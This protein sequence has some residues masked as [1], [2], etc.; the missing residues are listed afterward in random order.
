[1]TYTPCEIYTTTLDNGMQVTLGVNDVDPSVAIHLIYRVGSRNEERGRTG[2]AHLFEHLMFQGSVHLPKGEYFKLIHINGGRTNGFTSEELTVYYQTLPPHRVEMGLWLEA[3]R[4]GG[5]LLTESNIKNQKSVVIEEKLQ[6]ENQPYGKMWDHLYESFYTDFAYQHPIIGYTEDIQ[7]ASMEDIRAFY[8]TYYSPGNANLAVVGAIDPDNVMDSIA[9]LFGQ[10]GSVMV[11]PPSIE[12]A[13]PQKP[14]VYNYYD[15]KIQLPA[16]ILAYPAPSFNDSDQE[17]FLILDSLLA[18]GA[19]SRL[20]QR[21]LKQ[22]E[23]VLQID[24][25]PSIKLG[26]SMFVIFAVNNGNH[27]NDDIREQVMDVLNQLTQG[28]IS[29]EELEKSKTQL[30]AQTIYSLRQ[31]QNVAARINLN[32]MY[33]NDPLYTERMLHRLEKITLKDVQ[34]AA[35]QWLDPSKQTCVHILPER[36]KV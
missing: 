35:R 31:N 18:E 29:E 2:L 27:S 15:P 17:V 9:R 5:L 13:P 1:M 4:M 8:D 16:L 12:Q 33:Y 10:I 28:S 14:R 26:P 34:R 23:S 36:P 19:S 25:S 6:R 24:A 22:E 32:R 11:S 21:L 20:Y 3:D 7:Q 30:R